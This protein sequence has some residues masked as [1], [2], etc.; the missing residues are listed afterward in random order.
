VTRSLFT[1]LIVSLILGCTTT[2]QLQKGDPEFFWELSTLTDKERVKANKLLAYGLE[3]EALYT[4][5]DTLKPMSSLGF[6]L[7]YKIAKTES[8]KDGKA[9]VVNLE[10]DST[11]LA[12]QE[13][14][15][16]NRILKHLSNEKLSFHL[17]PFKQTWDGTRNLQILVCRTDVIANLMIKKAAFFGQWGFT[18][19]TDPSVI[20]NTIEFESKND[21]YRAYGYL[22]GYPDHAVDFFVKAS[23]AQE[24]TG[25]FVE[26]NFFHIPVAVG[27]SGYFTYAIPQDYVP[28]QKDSVIYRAAATKL[29]QYEASKSAKSDALSQIRQYW[30]SHNGVK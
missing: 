17:I 30:L 7:S 21:R 29:A 16:W 13:L 26:R 6:T 27:T 1:F 10:Q 12:L 8:M 4:L 28:D 9:I 14:A 2:H 25:E 20:L 23:I 18:E 11:Q 3:H 22:F 24:Q 19:S 5:M 15:Q